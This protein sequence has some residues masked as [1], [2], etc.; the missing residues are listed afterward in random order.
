[1]SQVNVLEEMTDIG[2]RLGDCTGK[3]LDTLRAISEARAAFHS[4]KA[5][6]LCAV[7]ALNKVLA[8]LPPEQRSNVLRSMEDKDIAVCGLLHQVQNP[9]PTGPETKRGPL[10][11]QS[12]TDP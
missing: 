2:K 12:R 3:D 11:S 7:E 9:V 1:M 6:L 4:A 5:D 10:W 8:S